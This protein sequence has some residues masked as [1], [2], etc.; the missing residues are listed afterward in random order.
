[1]VPRLLQRMYDAIQKNLEDA[2]C[3]NQWLL[4]MALEGKM[5]QLKQDGTVINAIWDT[6]IFKKISAKLGGKVKVMVTGS[7][8]I[9]AEILNKLKCMFSVN[10]GEG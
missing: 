9:D 3:F 2:G 10:I 4:G 7:A 8:P 6:L 1:M 5:A